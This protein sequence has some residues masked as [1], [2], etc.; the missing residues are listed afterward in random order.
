MPYPVP[1]NYAKK[2]FW[3]SYIVR[4]GEIKPPGTTT[5][6][7]L[8]ITLQYYNYFLK[9]SYNKTHLWDINTFF[10]KWGRKNGH[11]ALAPSS[12]IFCEVRPKKRSP[13]TSALPLPLLGVEHHP[14][15]LTGLQQ[16]AH[17]VRLVV[18]L[19]LGPS[20]PV[21]YNLDRKKQN[22][23]EMTFFVLH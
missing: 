2:C 20:P 4:N 5:H 8:H 3:D 14:E 16:A 7:V 11:L 21:L 22:F 15:L 19:C 6:F 13:G 12:Y 17:Q 23:K 9:P 10:V 1:I 18:H